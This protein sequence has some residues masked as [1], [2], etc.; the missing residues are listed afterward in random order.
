MRAATYQMMP[1]LRGF[2]SSIKRLKWLN[3]QARDFDRFFLTA[4]NE[5]DWKLELDS[6]KQKET[7]SVL[8]A[9]LKYYALADL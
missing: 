9:A 6:F 1:Y 7:D 4:L 2:T 8:I 3:W 5:T